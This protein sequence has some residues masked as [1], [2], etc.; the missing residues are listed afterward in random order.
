MEKIKKGIALGMILTAINSHS[1]LYKLTHHSRAN[2][3]NN[4]SITWWAGHAFWSRIISYHN[5]D[6][7]QKCL[8]DTFPKYTWRN[9]AVHWGEAPKIINGKWNVYAYHILY[10]PNGSS[11]TSQITYVDDC[12]IYDGW[13]D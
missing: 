7:Q 11:Y 6:G 4:E 9:A 3:V 13:W 10:L 12:S 1:G 2:C 8:I 5:Y